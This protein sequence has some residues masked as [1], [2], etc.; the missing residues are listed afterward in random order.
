[1]K[2]FNF[3][4]VLVT[5]AII[6]SLFLACKKPPAEQKKLDIKL[7][8]ASFKGDLGEIK[9]LLAKGADPNT[10][11]CGESSGEP[12][13]TTPLF[14]ALLGYN[15]SVKDFLSGNEAYDTSDNDRQR[16]TVL[17]LLAAGANPNTKEQTQP[18]T[19]PLMYAEFLKSS[20][21]VRALTEAGADP[22]IRDTQGKTAKDYGALTGEEL[23]NMVGRHVVVRLAIAIA[24]RDAAEKDIVDEVV[25]KK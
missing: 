2:N 24:R 8:M 12:G 3:A 15:K 1:M 11:Q 23:K 21:L 4:V 16:L 5:L 19:T 6:S 18:E 9:D 14:F 17:A 25:P 7:C 13:Y 20:G 22:N 10:T